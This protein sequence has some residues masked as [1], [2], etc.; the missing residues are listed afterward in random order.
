MSSAPR[1]PEARPGGREAI[2]TRRRIGGA[3]GAARVAEADG[4][5]IELGIKKPARFG[6]TFAP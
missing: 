1:Q 5:L 6:Q 4:Y 2:A 3:A